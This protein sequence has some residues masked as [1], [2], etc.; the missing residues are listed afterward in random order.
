MYKKCSK[1]RKCTQEEIG[2]FL[3]ISAI[4]VEI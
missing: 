1:M 4:M 3:G 2:T